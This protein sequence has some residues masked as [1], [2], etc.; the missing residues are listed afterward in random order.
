MG[1]WLAACTM[2]AAKHCCPSEITHDEV[3]NGL[4]AHSARA[5]V[6]LVTQ[7][8]R[9]VAHAHAHLV[10]HRDLKPSNILVDARGQVHLLNFGI[11][12][13]IDTQ[14]GVAGNAAGTVAGN[15]AGTVAGDAPALTQAF[16]PR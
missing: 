15:V 4:S 10:M 5:C 14:A 16:A 3:G 13:L 8:A 1:V 9:A 6:G 7:V 12:R 11:A 2:V